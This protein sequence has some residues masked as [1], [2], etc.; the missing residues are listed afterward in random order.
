YV[1]TIKI[2]TRIYSE[3]KNM[4][5]R[6][7]FRHVLKTPL[8][9]FSILLDGPGSAALSMIHFN[10]QL[11]ANREQCSMKFQPRPRSVPERQWWSSNLVRQSMTPLSALIELRY[12]KL[13]DY[14][15]SKSSLYPT[16]GIL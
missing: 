12:S 2:A 11:E 16:T 5:R 15:P 14:R 6:R 1:A 13:R 9:A 10:D 7:D 3:K 8:P 4:L